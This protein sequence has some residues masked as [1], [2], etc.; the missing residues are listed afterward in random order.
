MEI[1]PG[2]WW[3]CDV[4]KLRLFRNLKINNLSKFTTNADPFVLDYH[5][6][7]TLLLGFHLADH[8][9]HFRKG[10]FDSHV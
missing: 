7:V 1:D 3:W 10:A 2:F 4:N 6:I 5:R 9:F 8:W